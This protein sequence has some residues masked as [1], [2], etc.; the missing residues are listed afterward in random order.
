MGNLECSYFIEMF[1]II[2]GNQKIEVLAINCGQKGIV[3]QADQ[4]RGKDAQAVE[5]MENLEATFV[6]SR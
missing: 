4:F 2:H 6:P 1:V 5:V 3:I